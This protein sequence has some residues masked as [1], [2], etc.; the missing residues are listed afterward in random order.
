MAEMKKKYKR[1]QDN[2]LSIKR[3][4]MEISPSLK[5]DLFSLI[6]TLTR[7]YTNLLYGIITSEKIISEALASD[8]KEVKEGTLKDWMNEI[9][10]I[11]KFHTRKIGRYLEDL[12]YSAKPLKEEKKIKIENISNDIVQLNIEEFSCFPDCSGSELNSKLEDMFLDVVEILRISQ[13]EEN[14][15]NPNGVVGKLGIMNINI[16]PKVFESKEEKKKRKSLIPNLLRPPKAKKRKSLSNSSKKLSKKRTKNEKDKENISVIPNLEKINLLETGKKKE[17]QIEEKN[18]LD[19]LLTKVQ[20]IKTKNENFV[21][22]EIQ[23]EEGKIDLAESVISDITSF[24][25]ESKTLESETNNIKSETEYTLKSKKELSEASR[26][27]QNIEKSLNFETPFSFL[28][29][30]NVVKMNINRPL[31]SLKSKSFSDSDAS[32]N[33]SNFSVK[34]LK[35]PE[36]GK[37]YN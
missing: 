25:A 21:K 31:S 4:F 35:V 24:A 11:F 2:F 36:I 12:K 32:N 18:V 5:P 10:S 26:N 22:D 17:V 14:R 3:Q 9:N 7:S 33:F 28:R 16:S 19:T 13:I 34:Y 27:L 1:K 20:T 23:T 37:K 6:N 15:E 30:P 8:A 29:S